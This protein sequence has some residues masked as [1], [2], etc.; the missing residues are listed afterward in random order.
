MDAPMKTVMDF[1]NQW[2]PTKADLHQSMRDYLGSDG[3]W[4]NV[5]LAVTRGSDEAI[6][7][8]NGFDAQMPFEYISVEMLHG[9]VTGN[10][11]LTERI[12]H[13]HAAD[14]TILLSIRMMGVLEVEGNR[15]ARW[16]D[17]YDTA[18]LS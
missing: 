8:I 7:F 2:G 15:I 12:D 18:S 11:V 16:R 3:I 13:L 4:E 6:G 14:G 10:S 1:F 5:G 9:A 17:Y